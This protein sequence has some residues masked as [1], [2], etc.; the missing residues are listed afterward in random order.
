MLL[1]ERALVL[2]DRMRRHEQQRTLEDVD[3][4]AAV[5]TDEPFGNALFIPVPGDT[6]QRLLAS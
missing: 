2:F 4:L 6:N 5:D 1:A 3:I